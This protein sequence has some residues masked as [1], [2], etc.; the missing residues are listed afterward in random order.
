MDGGFLPAFPVEGSL[1]RERLTD[2]PQSQTE[3]C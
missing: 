1:R 3:A 2:L